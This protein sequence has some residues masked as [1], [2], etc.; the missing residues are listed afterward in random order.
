MFGLSG[1]SLEQLNPELALGRIRTDILTDFILAPTI[2]R[3]L[4]MHLT[5]CGST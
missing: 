1:D 5:T 3:C 4:H 2:R